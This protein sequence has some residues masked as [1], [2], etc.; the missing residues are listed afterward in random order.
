MTEPAN[1]F[2]R[3]YRNLRIVRTLLITC[4]DDC[5]P[6]WRPL[7]PS[8][9]HLPD[10]QVAQ[11]P[12]LVSADFALIAEGQDVPPELE[13]QCQ[14]DGIVRSVVYAIE[15]EDF[16][17][18]PTH[19]GDT[20]SEKAA[21]AVID[22]LRFETGHYSRCWEIST[23]HISDQAWNYLAER[24]DLDTPQALLFV[25]F[26]IPYSPAI[27]IKLLSTPWSDANLVQAQ[28]ITAEQ[29]RQ[30]YR[31]KGM[32]DDLVHILKLAG[33]ADVRI[34]ILDADAPVLEGLP[35]F[36]WDRSTR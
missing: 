4:E 20:S 16:D 36:G 27:G 8:Q 12:C 15:G 13:N 1:P 25:A 22:R 9:A 18:Q 33:Q 29:L 30:E 3:G 2:I 14:D 6:V 34:L 19:V 7:H 23:E 32:P 24:A 5:P 21:R 17:G 10:D 26:R 11:F 28:G 35:R 31:N